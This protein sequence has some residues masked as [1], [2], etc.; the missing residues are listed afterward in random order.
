LNRTKLY[1]RI[2]HKQIL[3]LYQNL[4]LK[5]YLIFNNDSNKLHIN[6]GHEVRTKF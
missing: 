2:D 3:I 6:M 4:K 5:I 1:Q